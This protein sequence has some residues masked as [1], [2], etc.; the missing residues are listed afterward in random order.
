MMSANLI[1]Y[2]YN[3]HGPD[4]EL[5]LDPYLKAEL[6]NVSGSV[7][8]DAGCG[9]APWAVEAAQNGAVVHGIDI[10]STMLEQAQVAV[11]QAGV[12]RQ[13]ELCQGDVANL[14]F[15]AH[16]FDRALSINVGCNLKQTM[17]T[18]SAK[19]YTTSG[20]GAHFREA[21]RVLKDGGQL[22]V[23]APAS[24]GVVFTDGKHSDKEVNAHI[25]KVL[26][27]IGSSKD[28]DVIIANLKELEEVQRATFVKRGNKLVLVTDEKLLR[29]GEPIW[30]KNPDGAELNYYHSEEEYLVAIQN[31]GLKCEEIKRPCFF[32]NVKYKAYRA[33]KDELGEAYIENH[34]FTIYY[35]TK[36]GEES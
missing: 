27:K 36:Q 22:F 31:A 21:Q 25:Q 10:R 35:V 17:Q 4:G 1:A 32:G 20:L 14:P 11:A 19:K 6:K 3:G 23:T 13:V 16:H 18:I 30:R 26:T 12:E 5:F 15:E 2:D 7:V 24:F 33:E 28:A 29:S 8:L 9:A 34:P